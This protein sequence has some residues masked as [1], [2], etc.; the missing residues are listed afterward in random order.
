MP[1]TEYDACMV[2]QREALLSKSVLATALGRPQVAALSSVRAHAERGDA[3]QWLADALKVES[4]GKSEL[5][6]VSCTMS[7]PREAAI[8]A[9]A[10]VDVYVAQMQHARQELQ[11]RLDKAESRISKLQNE[12]DRKRRALAKDRSAPA[13]GKSSIPH[14]H[15]ARDAA[16]VRAEIGSLQ[17]ELQNLTDEHDKVSIEIKVQPWVSEVE[18]AQEPKVANGPSL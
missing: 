18:H 10:V 17:R 12:L 4:P 2:R 14:A 7:D 8:L 3:A 11:N 16:G 5:V 6:V 15:G 13:A 1:E 9:N